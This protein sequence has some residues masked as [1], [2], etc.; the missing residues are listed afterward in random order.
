RDPAAFK[1]YR[2]KA[3]DVVRRTNAY[4]RTVA[5]VAAFGGLT[6]SF[7]HSI[8]EMAKEK[9][10]GNVLATFPLGVDFV[11]AA[12]PLIK[13]SVEVS[14][15]GVVMP[16]SGSFFDTFLRKPFTY[17]FEGQAPK[18]GSAS[19]AFK[20]I[21]ESKASDIFVGALFLNNTSGWLSR[22][23][24]CDP[25]ET[26]RMMDAIV[27]QDER[28][29]FATEYFGWSQEPAKAREFAFINAIP[30]PGAS[31]QERRL[32]NELLGK[33]HRNSHGDTDSQALAAVQRAVE[34][35]YSQ[36]SDQDLLRL[37]FHNREDQ[38]VYATLDLGAVSIRPVPSAE[39]VYAYESRIEACRKMSD[40]ELAADVPAASPAINLAP[41]N[42][43][44]PTRKATTQKPAAKP[45]TPAGR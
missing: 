4:M 30:E 42:V 38:A 29:K 5:G 15:K 12:A 7:G 45:G 6:V 9:N 16:L 39:S 2:T 10:F 20:F 43:T 13:K 33:D 34:A 24:M 44:T 8:A 26:G 28:T 11:K 17:S 23:R 37:V 40:R 36:W 41:V 18:Q 25:V 1:D 3:D 27:S 19:D 14:A 21:Q 31:R 32:S 35:K 22:V